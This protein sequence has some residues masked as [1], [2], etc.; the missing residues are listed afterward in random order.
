MKLVSVGKVFNQGMRPVSK[1]T[2]EQV[3]VKPSNVNEVLELDQNLLN[4]DLP[5]SVNQ[6]LHRFQLCQEEQE[7]L[8]NYLAKHSGPISLGPFNPIP[9]D[10]QPTDDE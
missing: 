7:N 3:T 9:V 1:Q 6:S 10:S 8:V 5:E 2:P 4:T